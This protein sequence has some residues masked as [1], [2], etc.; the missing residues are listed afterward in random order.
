[1]NDEVI[2]PQKRCYGVLLSLSLHECGHDWMFARFLDN[3]DLTTWEIPESEL[4]T[5]LSRH[6]MAA[7]KARLAGAKD[8]QLTIWRDNSGWQISS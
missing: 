6:L 5:Q 3:G 1:M 8:R 4:F 2:R 7:A